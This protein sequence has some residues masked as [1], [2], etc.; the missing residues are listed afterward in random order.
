V[1]TGGFALALGYASTECKI[2]IKMATF[3][4]ECEPMASSL[5]IAADNACHNECAGPTVSTSVVY[6][7]LCVTSSAS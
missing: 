4:G 5:E 3:T 2:D 7:T 1:N 6:D